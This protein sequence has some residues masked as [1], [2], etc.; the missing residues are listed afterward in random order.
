MPVGARLAEMARLRLQ[1]DEA[2]RN[3]QDI[4]Q[5]SIDL[6]YMYSYMSAER[7]VIR[8]FPLKFRSPDIFFKDFMHKCLRNFR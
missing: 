2:R 4:Q 3:V 8:L 1:Y 7:E 6:I 5:V